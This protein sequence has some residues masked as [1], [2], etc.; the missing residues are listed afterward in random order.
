MELLSGNE[1]IKTVGWNFIPEIEIKVWGIL[2]NL[3]KTI[4]LLKTNICNYKLYQKMFNDIDKDES[5][6]VSKEEVVTYIKLMSADIN[7][8]QVRKF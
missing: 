5:G 3:M 1:M 7:D 6:E 2:S 8:D 4:S